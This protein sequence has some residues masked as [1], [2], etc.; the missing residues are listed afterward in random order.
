MVEA[1]KLND[2]LYALNGVLVTAR[3][4]AFQKADPERLTDVLDRAEELPM[5][6]ARDDDLT[7]RYRQALVDLAQQHEGFDFVVQRF[8]EGME[9]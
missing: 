1:D 5:L 6:L 4:M 7:A 8:D 3:M 9:T 2:A